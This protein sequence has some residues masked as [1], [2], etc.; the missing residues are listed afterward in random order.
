ML[1]MAGVPLTFRPARGTNA[2]AG[3]DESSDEFEVP[4]EVPRENPR[5]DAA[6]V[7]A[8]LIQTNATAQWRH[9]GFAEA[10]I[11]ASRA[12]SGTFE[13]GIDTVVER[14]PIDLWGVRR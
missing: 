14:V 11:R 6:G 2:C 12:R 4:I 13:R 9:V 10:G 8:V 1:V 3:V 5:H 7:G